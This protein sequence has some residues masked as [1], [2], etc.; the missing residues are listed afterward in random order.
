LFRKTPG[1]QDT[2]NNAADFI[3]G[4]PVPQR[5]APIVEI[6]PFV[7]RT[8]PF[9]NNPETP[10][11]PTI[12]VTFTEAV[13]V[14]DNWILVSCAVSGPKTYTRSGGG[15]IHDVTI[16]EPLL[17]GET[18]TATVFKDEVHDQDL[19]DSGPNTDTL[20]SDYSW[21][22][23]VATGAPP[24]YPASV[25]LTMGNPTNATTDTDHPENY[26]MLKPEFA[27][28]YNADLGRPN[29]VSW[30][31]SDEW[32]GNLTRDDTFRADPAVPADWYRVQS[33]DFSGSGF[34]RG[35]LTP[36]ADRN[37][38]NSVPINQATF[39]MTNMMAQAPDNNQGPWAAFEGYLRTLLP[40]NEVYIVA[41]PAGIGGAGS[42]GSATTIADGHVAVPHDTW[43]AAL[44][45]PKASGDDILRVNCSSRTIAVIMPN[46]QG[47]RANPWE[48]YLTTVD[49]VE[50]L[51]GYDVFTSLPPQVQYCI[52]GG[53]NGVGN[54][55]ED[56]DPPV[57]QCGSAD[58]AWHADNVDLSCTATD[59]GSGL[60]HPADAS[61]S[62]STAVAAG[63]EDGNATTN[64]HQ[65]CDK[66]G[67]CAT[68][69]P[70][71]GNMIDRKAPSVACGTADSAWHNSNVAIGCTASDAA[72]VNAADAS[73]SLVTT[74]AAGTADANA[75]TG[76]RLVCDQAGNC[77]PA[78]PIAGNKVDLVGP[79]I[80][81]TRPAD[82]AFYQVSHVVT[83]SFSCADVGSGLATCT[84]T[85]ADGAAIDTS[86]LGAKS[87][88]VIAT[89]VAGNA[90]STTVTYNVV[91]KLPASIFINNIPGAAVNGGS[92]TPTFTYTGEGTTHVDSLT[93]SVCKVTG[94][95]VK[96]VSAGTC[97]LQARGTPNGTYDWAYGPLQSFVIAP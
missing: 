49:A 86:T 30:H 50:A 66:A 52:E 7:F 93:Q 92:F 73:F 91:E 90:S 44:V 59:S 40:A 47:I 94:G 72:L 21:S 32:T 11:D 70:I 3:T 83:A 78:G 6:G 38:A 36:N 54:L 14:G 95:V 9:A 69:G 37:N 56:N 87:F 8:D 61:F 24:P 82:G 84:G 27:L 19:D 26:L 65:V 28:S 67:N 23:A 96:F 71:A 35:H 75:S 77:S 55:P 39:L 63:I 76:S 79:A 57:I 13:D 58:G 85:V 89:D 88:S 10:R 1:A 74:V 46:T 34:D 42:N 81:L 64:S 68:A 22:F 20:Q 17:P 12:A 80:T 48:T 4:A 60:A 33:F 97:T 41:G 15:T 31:L 18:C 53:I 62:L 45:I 25:H 51:S 2:D 16:N 5:T 29:W 43:K